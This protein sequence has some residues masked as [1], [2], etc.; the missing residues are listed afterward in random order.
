MVKYVVYLDFKYEVDTDS[1][2]SAIRIAS[3]R[4]R[5]LVGRRGKI[6]ET[7][8]NVDVEEAKKT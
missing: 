1:K 4:H 7:L 3:R 8:E 6:L 2:D 5:E